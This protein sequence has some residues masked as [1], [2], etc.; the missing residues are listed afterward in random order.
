MCMVS[1]LSCKVLYP[2]VFE[3]GEI[4][5]WYV[6]VHNGVRGGVGECLVVGCDSKDVPRCC[7][8]F[9]P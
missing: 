1:N 9:L 6:I 7:V 8:T 2:L 4:S 3:F 5:W